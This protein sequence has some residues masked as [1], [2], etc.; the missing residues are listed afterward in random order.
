MVNESFSMANILIIDD[1]P[2]ICDMLSKLINH[3]GHKAAWQPTL[4]DGLKNALSVP[5]DIIFLDVQLPDGSGLDIIA[6]IR[7]TSSAPEV[8]IMTGYGNIDG[9]E[10]AIKSGAW[11]Y[12]QKTDSPS[13]IILPL[14]RAIQYRNTV[15]STLKPA[16]ALKLD[17]IV[18]SSTPMKSC[19]NQVAQAAA[20]NSNV[21]L[22]GETGT[23]KELFARAIH[24]NS[25]R[26]A[27]NFVVVDCAALPETL[28]ES[29]LFGHIKGA[30]T[31]A[32]KAQEGLV[33]QAHG[34]TLFL[35]EVGELPLSI[36]KVFLRV[37][38]EHRFRP[39]GSKHE[40]EVD[41]RLVAATNRNLDH[42]IQ[43]K[44]F[45]DDLLF[46]LRALAIALP[47][48][49]MRHED[50]KE[51]TAYYIAKLCYRQKIGS[52]GISTDFLDMLI[53]Y[54]WPG[55]VR[56]L[57][58]TLEMAISTAGE[59]EMLFSRHLPEH[60]RVYI[61]QT[62]LMGD[63]QPPSDKK[64]I[65]DVQESLPPLKIFRKTAV[66]KAEMEYLKKLMDIAKGKTAVACEI[67]GLSRS[68]LYEL[69]RLH[70]ISLPE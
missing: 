1:D 32:D 5:Y 40:V 23:G 7:S 60:L 8:I 61:A 41:F 3:M 55:N 65:I 10:I 37:L 33:S 67:S 45:R 46:R 26:A 19:Y 70:K 18:G 59:E 50:I 62:S 25:N 44:T 57:I 4:A 31:G 54:T 48:L 16:V 22:T 11:D 52:K 6:E 30:Y 39:V 13:K 36:Q 66:V 29:L 69:I 63:L 42:M 14:K 24:N 27:G 56:E 68:R 21:L 64:T 35:D 28:V 9:A 2:A 15:K 58:N 34:G 43:E 51:L 53:R 20:C 47:S 49:R 38:Q 12:I 17:G